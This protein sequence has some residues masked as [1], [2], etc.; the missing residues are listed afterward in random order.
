MKLI[1]QKGDDE[2][3]VMGELYAPPINKPGTNNGAAAFRLD[4]RPAAAE[5]VEDQHYRRNNKQ[6]VDQTTPD[7]ADHPQQPKD[8]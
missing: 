1:T 2:N 5:Q 4:G 8:Q 6:Q 7:A 3:N